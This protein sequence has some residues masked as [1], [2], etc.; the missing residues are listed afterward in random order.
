MRQE[1]ISIQ[2][3]DPERA[4]D[5]QRIRARVGFVSQVNADVEAGVRIASGNSNDARST[6]QDL[7]NYFVK[8]DLWLDRAYVNWHP[9]AVP[10]LKLIGGKMAQPWISEEQLIWDD[11]VN[12]EGVAA[13]YSHKFGESNCSARPARSR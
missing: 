3:R 1:S 11:D 5:R 12:P 9:S 7:D 2:N 13:L 8:K 10:G 4:A 6:N